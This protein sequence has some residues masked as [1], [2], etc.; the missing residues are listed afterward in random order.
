M[1]CFFHTDQDGIIKREIL[2]GH[3]DGV[4]IFRLRPLCQKCSDTLNETILN[5][6]YNAYLNWCAFTLTF[7]T[8]ISVIGF[9]IFYH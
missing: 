4:E 8:C 7:F 3:D 5:E 9:F 1:K 2:I 6:R